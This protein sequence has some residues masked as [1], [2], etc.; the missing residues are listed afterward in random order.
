LVDA[1]VNSA[2]ARNVPVITA[3]QMLDWLDGRNASRFQSINWS[4]NVLSFT[5]EVGAGANGLRMLLPAFVGSNQITGVTV[6]GATAGFTLETIKGVQYAIVPASAGAYQVSYGADI[7]AP[8]ISGRTATPS[9]NSAQIAWTTNEPS[10]SRVEFGTDPASL[11]SNVTS[12]ALVSAHALVLT[13]LSPSTT[14]YYRVVSVDET[15]NNVVSPPTD[16][17]PAS[18]TTLSPAIAGSVG[19]NGAGATV[20]LS[21]AATAS[22]TADSGGNYRFDGLGNGAYTV[23]PAKSGFVLTPASR[24]VTVNGADV[25]AVNFTAQEIVIS[26]AITPAANA[27]GATVA[28]SGPVSR[29]VAVDAAGAFTFSAIPNGS[30]TITPSRTNYTFTPATQTVT[31]SGASVTGVAFT[32]QPVPT[33]SISG[34]V[35]AAAS[36]ATISISGG[37]S[38]IADASGSYSAA[39]LLDGAYTVTPSKAGYTFAPSSATITIAGGNVSSVNFAANAVTIGGTVSGADA[40]GTTLTLSGPVGASIGVDGAGAYLFAGLPNGTYTVTPSKAGYAYTPANRVVTIAG[41]ASVSGVDFIARVIPIRKISGTISPAANGSGSVIALGEGTTVFANAAGAYQFTNIGDGTYAV[42]PQKAGF[43]FTPTSR[44]VTVAGVDLT[45]IDFTAT[46]VTVSG[47]IGP[48]P[49]GVGVT[50][51]LGAA[52][53]S[54]TTDSAGAFSFAGVTNGTY[55]VTP[56]KGGYSFT[57]ATRTVTVVNGVSVG[58]VDFTAALLP[59][60]IT[61]DAMKTAGRT[62]RSTTIASGAFST[63]EGN[64]LLLAFVSAAN[65]TAAPTTVTQVTGGGLTWTLVRRTNVQRGTSE[66]WRAWAAAKLTSVSVTATL[67]Q[68]VGAQITVMSFKGVDSTGTNGSGAIGASASASAP[69]GAPSVS[70]VTTRANSLVIGVGNDWDGNVARV[71]GPNQTLVS[72]FLSTDGDTFWVQRTT[73]MVPQSGTTVTINDTAP[74]NHQYNLTICEIKGGS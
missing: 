42:T 9:Y 17:A 40:A 22:V 56:S 57:P 30:Y 25:S 24:A 69:T 73:S 34:S 62:P 35:S 18:F 70:L 45:G 7:T 59:A 33:W 1:I 10:T 71:L 63:A 36:G 28:L 19:V 12:T 53:T 41:A 43:T 66:I 55:A 27:D 37:T 67:S 51:A 64:E 16:T 15:G 48:L 6:N 31:V 54:A 50:V 49:E 47:S 61:I 74:T 29:L 58:A 65:I 26:G 46:P 44:P 52:G 5:I 21:G 14:Y 38:V 13:G 11:I 3:R 39:G 23:T 8:V 72:Q 68:S 32:A 4:G 60:T 20:T 2:K